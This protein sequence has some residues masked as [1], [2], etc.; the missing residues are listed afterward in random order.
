MMTIFAMLFI[1]TKTYG[2]ETD[3]TSN[4]VDENLRNSILELAKKATGEENKTT[5][6][7]S[8]IDKIVEIAGGSSLKLANKGIKDLS[9]IEVFAK[10]EVTWIFLDWNEITDLTPLKDFSNLTKISFSGNQVEDVT[11]LASLTNL[12]NITA[13]NNPIKTIEPLKNLS[14]V[15]YICLDGNHLTN[16]NT[17]Q[18]W[19]HL[20]EISFQNNQIVEVPNL[21]NL[22][23]L[24][25]INISHNKIQTINNLSRLE[26]L[27]KLEI[28]NN[29]LTSL[30]GIQNL[31]NLKVL[32]CS[33]NQ[34]SEL[35]GLET[36]EKLENLNINK[37]QI[38]DI[39]SLQKN[40]E[41]EYLYMDYN[42]MLD[43]E[44]LRDLANLKKYTIYNQMIAVEIKEKLVGEFILVPL[45]ELYRD[46]YD[47]TAFIYKKDINTQ[48][49]GTEEYEIDKN[50]Q[51]I[52]LRAEDLKNNTI[53]V[54]V[55]D[56][57]NTFLKYDIQIDKVAPIIEG[58]GNNQI[59]FEAVI[60][61]SQADD[62][63][64]VILLKE[65]EEIS[66]QLGEE[67]SGVGKY[68][69]IVRDRAQNE[70]KISFE[71]KSELNENEK[72]QINGQYIMGIQYDTKLETFIELLDGNIG[73]K[74]YR[75]KQLLNNNDIVA[76]GDKLVTDNNKIFYLIV[77]GD[78]SKDGNTNIKDLVKLRKYLL[79]IEKFDEFQK[80]AADLSQDNDITIKDLVQIRKIIISKSS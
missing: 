28:D 27:E 65:G 55:L 64:E 61:T 74:V 69:L 20:E 8:D 13:I 57:T 47:E 70:T 12:T 62:I 35:S 37:N 24:E 76:T 23:N 72:Y 79:K 10:K 19:N 3:I 39:T 68:T 29:E 52:K 22:T 53:T 71:I 50:K 1:T 7:E 66:Y 56:E 46:L 38:Q 16:I 67:I 78:I 25:S 34:I 60:P 30:E 15:K 54:Q 44:P 33:N 4:F 14:N 58:V 21:S 5:I 9:G 42:N 80:K 77:R 2:A 51:N 17:I 73:Y 43:F 6:Y 40:Q 63:Q 75:N 32:S 48:V 36:L 59:Y 26:K 31:V 49:I 11:P 18:N 41:I 45:P